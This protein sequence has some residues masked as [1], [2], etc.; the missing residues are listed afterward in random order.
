MSE[1]ELRPPGRP[2]N[3]RFRYAL[4]GT[5]CLWLALAAVPS[6]AQQPGN[7]RLMIEMCQKDLKQFCPN[8]G[9]TGGAAEACL[10]QYFVSLSGACRA[11]LQSNAPSGVSSGNTHQP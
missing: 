9:R 3:T 8:I 2:E 11:T 5:A 10:R 7:H 1:N 6:D 4:A